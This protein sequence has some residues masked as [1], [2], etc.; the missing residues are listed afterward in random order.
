MSIAL[1][2]VLFAALLPYFTVVAAKRSGGRYDNAAPREWARSLTGPR[3]RAYAAHQNHFEFFPFFAVAVLLAEWKTGGTA[4][5][6]RLALAI[7]AS[8]LLYTG[9]YVADRP[10]LRSIAWA[11]ALFGTI[12]LFGLAAAG[13]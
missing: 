11:L 12:G 7:I 9:A 2:C 10:T 6:D 4:G 13:K 8:R 5:I 1:W 3:Q